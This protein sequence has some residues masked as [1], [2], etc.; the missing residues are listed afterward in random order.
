[1]CPWENSSARAERAERKCLK[2]LR[3]CGG[4]CWSFIVG[5]FC[6]W[7]WEK[8]VKL[9]LWGSNIICEILFSLCKS[10]REDYTTQ[11]VHCPVNL[12]IFI[13]I[14]SSIYFTLSSNWSLSV[15]VHK[16]KFSLFLCIW[17]FV[18]GILWGYS[19]DFLMILWLVWVGRKILTWL[20]FFNFTVAPLFHLNEF[21]YNLYNYIYLFRE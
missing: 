8:E 6:F 14:A 16:N 11:L 20:Q 5:S 1:M 3:K 15:F 19:L 12:S 21:G 17:D 7:K 13:F 2:R 10:N 18:L 4:G 9:R